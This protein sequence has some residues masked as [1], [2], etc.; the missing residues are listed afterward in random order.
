MP[1]KFRF[2]YKKQSKPFTPVDC[3]VP[4]ISSVFQKASAATPSSGSAPELVAGPSGPSSGNQ[5]S[6]ASAARSGGSTSPNHLS[7]P[8]LLPQSQSQGLLQGTC[9]LMRLERP[10]RLMLVQAFQNDSKS[11]FSHISSLED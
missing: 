9:S 4:E 1:R 10:G 8:L 6:D 5:F 2:T 7:Q 3:H 11:L